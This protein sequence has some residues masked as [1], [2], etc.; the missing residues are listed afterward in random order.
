[1]A[2]GKTIRAAAKPQMEKSIEV[3]P[4]HQT[5]RR[6]RAKGTRFENIVLPLAERYHLVNADTQS[7][8]QP[9]DATSAPATK[10]FRVDKKMVTRPLQVRAD[11]VG[12]ATTRT[13]I[14]PKG[15]LVVI[16]AKATTGAPLTKSQKS[17][18]PMMQTN[19]AMVLSGTL[20]GKTYAA[21]HVHVVIIRRHTKAGSIVKAERAAL[22]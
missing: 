12:V 18:F 17:A 6:S 14:A 10:T 8:I 2:S 19:G 5:S 3:R 1:M 4:G 22:H 13:K 15:D 9:L 7:R 16:E 20:A 11:L 21:G